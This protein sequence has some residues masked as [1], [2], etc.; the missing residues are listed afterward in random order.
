MNYWL[1]RGY[2]EDEAKNEISNLQVTF[3]LD[4][5][6][7][8]YG[9]EL[10]FIKWEERQNNWQKTLKA[11]DNYDEINKSKNIYDKL[12]K[13]N[14]SH[15]DIRSILSD[16]NDICFNYEE[17][18]EY[19]NKMIYNRPYMAYTNENHIFSKLKLHNY[20]FIQDFNEKDILNLISTF[21]VDKNRTQINNS[22]YDT[23]TLTTNENYYLKSSYEIDFYLICKE[24][25]IEFL[26]G[27][28]Y[29]NSTKKYD[30]YLINKNIFIEI[31]GL[32]HDEN[33]KLQLLD[34]INE[35]NCMW[36][37]PTKIT[38][39]DFLKGICK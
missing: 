17:L 30:F 35:F 12:I 36:Y 20:R 27:L 25:N 31:S 16:K 2:S 32:L 34:K 37:D 3:S 4:I 33:Y 5:C 23:Y 9:P 24:L 29:E 13:Q 8:K 10:G 18:S 19:I 28:N 15:D 21:I 39:R 7:K 11:K 26:Y 1:L 22:L 6:I 14:L 38:A